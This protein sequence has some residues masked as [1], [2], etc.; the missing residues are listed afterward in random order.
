MNK[1]TLVENKEAAETLENLRSLP[2]EEQSNEIGTY[3]IDFLELLASK[4][5][6]TSEKPFGVYR[7]DLLYDILFERV[8]KLDNN[9][10]WTNENKQKLLNVNDK[11]MQVFE[12]AYNE[13][14][15]VAGELEN[16]IKN[17]DTFIKDYEI[18]IKMTPYTSDRFYNDDANGNK[19][20]YIL[21]EPNPPLSL[22]NFSFG[23]TNFHHE[24]PIYM[25]KTM[26]WNIQYFGDA[27]K[28]NYIC[29]EIHELLD[30]HIWSLYDII[31]IDKIRADVEVIHQHYIENI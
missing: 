16:R 28:D 13:A 8:M 24:K 23:H 11:L 6:E 15:S 2:D 22:I 1:E 12:C 20:G 29:Y 21:S 19:I 31:N 5:Y 26:N 3:S 9:F 27:F 10:E 7:F 25:D 17:N 14:L 18:E 4:I 30:T